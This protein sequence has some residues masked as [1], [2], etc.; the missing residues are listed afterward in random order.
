MDPDEIKL[1]KRK[2]DIKKWAEYVD[3]VEADQRSQ[4]KVK[5]GPMAGKNIRK[6]NLL[7]AKIED[8]AKSYESTAKKMAELF[9]EAVQS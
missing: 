4:S 1:Q 6:I 3:Q 7:A 9:P 8:P 2:T 5:T